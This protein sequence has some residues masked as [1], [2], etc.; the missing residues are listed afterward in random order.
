MFRGEKLARVELRVA[1]EFNVIN[2]LAAFAAA[3]V[4]GAKPED[5]ARSLSRFAGVHRRFELTGIIDGVKM[6]HDYGHNPAE[7]RSA[8]S[9]AKMQHAN[10]VWAVMQPHT[11]SRVKSLFKDY[12]TCTQKEHD[13]AC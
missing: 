13:R 2:S 6:Y 8:L 3:H 7:M 9:V 4:V 1:G 10:R 5:I 11:Y 12:L